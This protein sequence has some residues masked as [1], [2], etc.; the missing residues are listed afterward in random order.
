PS[1]STSSIKT[2]EPPPPP[3]PKYRPLFISSAN[4]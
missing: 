4:H 1:L 2:T 3:P